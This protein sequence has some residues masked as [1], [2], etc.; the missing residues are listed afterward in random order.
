MSLTAEIMTCLFDH[1]SVNDRLK[2]R[3]VNRECN[4][5]LLVNGVIDTIRFNRYI[6]FE[7]YIKLFDKV[8]PAFTLIDENSGYNVF[9]FMVLEPTTLVIIDKSNFYRSFSPREPLPTVKHIRTNRRDIPIDP[10]LFPN[11]VDI[12]YI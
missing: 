9:D 3:A 11:L 12:T 6:P 1:L 2:C 8:K 7:A 10:V 5:A 4:N